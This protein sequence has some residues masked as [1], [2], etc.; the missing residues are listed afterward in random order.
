VR[1]ARDAALAAA[2]AS[3]GKAA[4]APPAEAVHPKEWALG[5]EH[6]Q[7]G[8]SGAAGKLKVHLQ[9]DYQFVQIADSRTMVIQ[10][11][12]GSGLNPSEKVTTTTTEPVAHSFYYC[13]PA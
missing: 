8:A 10:L 5:M 3:G 9:T 4:S 12:G 1:A 13:N 11:L 6:M 7:E 2:A